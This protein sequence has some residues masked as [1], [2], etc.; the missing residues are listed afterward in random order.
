MEHSIIRLSIA[1]A[2]LAFTAAAQSTAT[3]SPSAK[4]TQASSVSGALDPAYAGFGIEPSNL[5]SFTGGAT[6]N[7]LSVNLLANLGNYS[8]VPPHLRIGGNTG[9]NMIYDASYNEYSLQTNPNPTGQGNVPSDLYTFGPT[10]WEALD[11]F[12][13]NTPITFGLNL[14]YEASDYISNIVTEASACL[15]G[16]S[17]VKLSSFEVGNEPDLYL[18]N[19]FRS[20][21]WGG[22]V[23]TQEWLTRAA[24]VY[25]QVLEPAGIAADFFE[26]PATASTIGTTFEIDDLIQ[27]GIMQ[28]QNGSS[29]LLAGWN[30]HDYFYYVG[31]SPYD[32]TLDYLMELSNTESQFKYWTSEVDEALN[33]SLPYYLREMASAGPIG[34]PGISDTFGAAIWT[35]NFLCYAATVGVSSVQMHMT[36]DSYAA[37][38]APIE[39][40]GEAP[41]VRPSYYAF[42]AMAM[43]I[44][45]GNGTT[46]IA[47]ITPSNIPSDYTN[48]VRCYAA[49]TNGALSAIVLINSQLSNASNPSPGSLSFALNLGSTYKSQN[50]YLSTLTADGADSQN[51]TIWQGISYED[52]G[53]GKPT[54]LSSTPNTTQLDSSGNAV[55]NVRDSQAVIANIGYQLGSHEVL[56]NGTIPP[57]ARKS[58]ASSMSST[59]AVVA[60]LTTTAIALATTGTASVTAHKSEGRSH[61]HS[62]RLKEVGGRGLGPMWITTFAVGCAFAMLHVMASG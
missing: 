57:T 3:L 46:Q 49:Y 45:S 37:A 20:G 9:D 29:T 27:D 24:A 51:G 10:Y 42:A 38:W 6:T 26:A 17:N 60:S 13:V 47:P 36:D 8:G 33:S 11:R 56:V 12:P 40:Y 14:A 21:S 61:S 31:V 22:Q 32:L 1:L 18:E 34:L 43:L 25:S 2:S 28:G 50:L 7:A 53:T 16:L 23:Y 52:S 44:G 19:N 41:H 4:A 55:V 5:Y 58:S 48:N 39:M 59:G 54:I 15:K 30:Q 35:L 62:V